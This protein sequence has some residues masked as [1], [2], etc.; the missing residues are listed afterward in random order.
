M[1]LEDGVEKV[2]SRNWVEVEGS[3]VVEVE[4]III[5]TLRFYVSEGFFKNK[6]GFC[7]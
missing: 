1:G 6:F 3:K 4:A 5:K 2:R 7:P